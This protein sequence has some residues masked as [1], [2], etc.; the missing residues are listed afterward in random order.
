MLYLVE[1]QKASAWR[2]V[3]SGRALAHRRLNA[4][5]RA[6]IAAQLLEQEVVIDLSVRQ[7]AQ[8]L[9]VS[10]PYILAARQLSSATREAIVN[11]GDLM[12]F[13]SLL[14]PNSK[15]LALPKLPVTDLELADIVRNV[16][17]ERVLAIACQV[18]KQL[19]A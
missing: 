7:V 16:G 5:Q 1:K 19:V 15:L 13:A 18:E 14:P 2:Q 10:V 4:R 6:V 11:G 8:L 3:I 12:S 9:G 17:I